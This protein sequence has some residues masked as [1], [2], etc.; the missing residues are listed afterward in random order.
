MLK[1][2][3]VMFMA[4]LLSKLYEEGF[5]TI[6]KLAEKLSIELVHHIQVI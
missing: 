2:G 3:H 4:F 6:P 5:G 1:I